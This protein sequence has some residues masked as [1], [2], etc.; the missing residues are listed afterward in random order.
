MIVYKRGNGDLERFK[1]IAQGNTV[2]P[3]ITP[4]VV[5]ATVLYYQEEYGQGAI[6]MFQA[7]GTT[8]AK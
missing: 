7:K 2:E 5:S 4:I 8:N 3:I 1:W 6:K